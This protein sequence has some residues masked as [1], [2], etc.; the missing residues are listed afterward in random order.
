MTVIPHSDVLY[1]HTRG[2]RSKSYKYR[3]FAAMLPMA[4]ANGSLSVI[5]EAS[6]FVREVP[7]KFPGA[8]PRHPMAIRQ[9]AFPVKVPANAFL[10]LLDV[11]FKTG[12][13]GEG[14][15]VT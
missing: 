15:E 7:G 13:A 4:R 1:V 2:L 9:S 6:L 10:C 11:H 5:P 3:D 8:P 12:S 14:T